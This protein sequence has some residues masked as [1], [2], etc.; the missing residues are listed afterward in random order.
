MHPL[1]ILESAMIFP[2]HE[3]SIR[4]K[5]EFFVMNNCTSQH[6]ILGNDYLNIYG[7]DINSHKD[8]YFTI[9]KNKRQKFAFPLEKGEISVIRQV[10]DE[11]KETFVADKL[12]EVQKSPELTLKMKEDIIEIL[13]QY[14]EAFAADNEPLSGIKG[15]EVDIIIKVESLYPPLSKRKSYPACP[16][17]REASKTYI[18]KLIKL[19]VLKKFAHNED[20]EVTTPLFISRNNNK[21]RMV[22]D[23]RSL[24]NYTISEKTPIP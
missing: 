16:R 21:S 12:I 14:I 20:V 15:H 4:L 18:N 17:A 13:F 23:F 5:V 3:G 19:G 6:F 2:H 24:N 9:G 1:G 22:G 11:D 8:I 10:E 7:I